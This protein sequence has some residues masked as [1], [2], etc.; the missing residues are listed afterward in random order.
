MT[1]M[2]DA[3]TFVV[4]GESLAAGT[5]HFSLTEDVQEHSFP[6]LVAEKLGTSLDQPVIEAPGV[7][8]VG[9]RHLP[10]LVP[11]LLQTSVLKDFPRDA[12][13][14]GNLSVPGASVADAVE[15]R[16]QAPMVWTDDPQQ[17]LMNLILG[18][19]SLTRGR[20]KPPTMLEYARARKPTLVLIA[21]GYQEVLEPLVPGHVHCGRHA[22]LGSFE[23]HYR[24]LLRAFPTS[25]ATVVVATIPDPLDTA[26][27]SSLETAA[28]ILRTEASFLKSQYGLET[29]DLIGLD[30]L[31]EIGCEFLARQVSGKLPEGSVITA[32]NAE[33]ISRGVEA[34]N[35]GIRKLAGRNRLVFDLHDYLRRVAEDGAEVGD[36]TLSADYLGGFYL[37][38]GV[39]PGR[40]GHALIANE[41]IAL[42]S[43]ECSERIGEVDVAE[44][45]SA[46]ANTLSKV[47]GGPTYTGEYLE[48]RTAADMPPLPP[49][50][51]SALNFF[52]PFDPA[53]FNI[54][55]IQTTFPDSPFDFGGVKA[56]NK[57]VPKVGI[58]AGGFSDPKITRPLVLPEGLEQT[59]ELNKE[60]SYYGDAF[61]VCDLP[62]EKPFI[63]GLP[64]FG[65]GGNTF[66]GGLA[67]VNTHLSGKMRIRFTEPDEHGV[68]HFEITHPGGLTGDDGALAAPKLFKMP[69]QHH[70]AVDV[71]GIVSSGDLDL[72][73]GYVTNFRYNVMFVNTAIYTLLKANP[74][75]PQGPLP[76]IFPGPP[77]SGSTWGRFDQRE[78]GKLDFTLAANL[79]LPLGK[80]A[81]DGAPI[82]FP[83]PFGNPHFECASI[84]TRGTTLHPNIHL[85]TKESPGRDLGDEAPE[86]PVNTVRE[87]AACVH[88]N[89]FGDVFDL[90]IDEL[91]GEGVGRSHL[92]GR[93][94]F[95]FGPRFG[96]SVP[97]QVS[98]LPPG[99]LLSEEPIPLPYLPPGTAR[100]MIGFNEQIVYPSGVVYHQSGLSSSMDPNNLAIGA[101]DLETGRVI[102][103]FLNRSF[104]VQQLFV[105]LTAIEP[106]TPGDSFNYQGPARFETGPGGELVFSFNGEVFV[107]YPKG[108]KFPGPSADGNPPYLVV[109]ESR[110]D[111]FLRLQATCGGA[112]ATGVLESGSGTR[113]AAIESTS[114]IGE[115]FSYAFR[116]PCDPAAAVDAFFE[117]TNA[118]V[119][120]TFRLTRLSWVRAG[121]APKGSHDGQ[122]DTITFG[123][124]GTWSRDDDLH[125][126]SVHISTAEGEPYVGIQVDGGTTSN[127]NTKP[128]RLEDTI[129][130][131]TEE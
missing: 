77:N 49:G 55:P 4:L 38:N 131:E 120:G 124:F 35:A 111:P 116:I 92:M 88:N 25:G 83:L 129:P 14:L 32:G 2:L 20:G 64:T 125:Q 70:R 86:I 69:A 56:I 80:E 73:T 91:G 108:F 22:D 39:F 113:P 16:P 42:L 21:L 104:V 24:K 72:E 93:L 58:P 121:V 6:A 36:R 47:A 17:T 26:Y 9:F 127:V 3:E 15:R 81:P 79:W 107:P 110:L 74:G 95:Q 101:I 98:F 12:A 76:Q 59:L 7:G 13:D 52:P 118:E 10:A 11:D 40:T 122:P 99:G 106:C 130:L 33:K 19:P 8:N 1:R 45:M 54:F 105:N 63:H 71:P 114:S 34:L 61:R 89:N 43:R 126:V 103:E 48:P 102:G 109:R 90:G 65:G 85:T 50:D 66:F 29:G 82:R 119:V 100:G 94:R 18:V 87:F 117:Y 41:L 96:D 46:D 30:A 67:M 97:F 115:P 112:P 27:F 51:P 68:S 128:E 123:G 23:K 53:K 84:V 31:I 60:G 78:D 37:L 44:V 62:D 5:G 28:H 57:C 75:L